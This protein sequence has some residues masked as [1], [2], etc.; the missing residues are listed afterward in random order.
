MLHNKY[1]HILSQFAGDYK[2]SIHGR[3]LVNKVPLSQKAIALT[4]KELEE[5]SILKSKRTGNLVFYSLNLKTNIKDLILI[6][7]IQN[8]IIFLK[9]YKKLAYILKEDSRVVGIFGSYAK[10]KNKPDSDIDIFIIG[11]KIR[12]DYD[13]KGKIFDLNIS[14]KYF[15]DDEFS[16]L[17]KQKNPLTNE[18]VENHIIIF[19]TETFINMIWR[20][21]YGL[22]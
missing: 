22:D 17:L 16:D 8:K 18:I 7:E 12:K 3:S 1:Y 21:H 11:N 14:I 5:Q 2:K 9:R 10:G 19:N 6:T 20:K 15:N 4:L 13:E